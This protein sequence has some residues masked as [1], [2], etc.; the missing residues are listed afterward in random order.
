MYFLCIPSDGSI[1]C[2][3]ETTEEL[4]NIKNIVFRVPLYLIHLS[5]IERLSTGASAYL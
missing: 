3:R 1:L 4:N 2:G 5:V